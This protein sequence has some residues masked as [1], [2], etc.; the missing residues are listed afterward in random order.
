MCDDVAQEDVCRFITEALTLPEASRRLFSLCPSERTESSLKQMRYAG[1]ERR[2]EVQ[3]L[4]AGLIKEQEDD[5]AEPSEAE[6]AEKA[7]AVMRSS[8]EVAAEREEE[9]K[10]L[11]ARAKERGEATA[12]RLSYEEAE[13]EAHRKEQ[14]KYYK[15]PL[16]KDDADDDA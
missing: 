8:A 5:E 10:A 11:L 16:P 3:M 2:E 4:L 9:L 15:A 7:E 14:E 13:K 6:A 12:K 1:Y